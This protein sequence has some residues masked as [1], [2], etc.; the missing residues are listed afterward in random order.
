[1]LSYCFPIIEYPDLSQHTTKYLLPVWN[2]IQQF[3]QHAE[4]QISTNLSS[5]TQQHPAG[6]PSDN[7]DAFIV[8]FYYE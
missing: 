8:T 2:F 7:D 4:M 6:K 1:M 3:F 5:I